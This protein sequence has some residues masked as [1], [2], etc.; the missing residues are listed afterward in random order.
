MTFIIA[1]G[2]F[3]LFGITAAGMFFCMRIC[4]MNDYGMPFTAPIFPFS[5]DS[6]RDTFVRANW[7][8]LAKRDFKVQELSGAHISSVGERG[9]DGE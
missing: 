1:G 8:T 7:R 3:G 5:R 2:V 6:M 9:E 4:S